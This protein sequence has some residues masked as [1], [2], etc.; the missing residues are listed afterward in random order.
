ML[1]TLLLVMLLLL[2]LVIALLSSLEL[3]TNVVQPN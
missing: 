2:Q 3:L 1:P